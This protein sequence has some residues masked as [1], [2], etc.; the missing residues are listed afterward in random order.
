[1]RKIALALLASVTFTG[2]NASTMDDKVYISSRDVMVGDNGIFVNIDGTVYQAD[3]LGYD[4]YG[5]NVIVGK[6][7]DC[8]CHK[9]AEAKK[10]REEEAAKKKQQE[11]QQA[12]NQQTSAL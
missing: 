2:V 10:K 7:L 1:M 5:V 8:G 12:Q 9:C 3:Q 11:E 4:E 6:S